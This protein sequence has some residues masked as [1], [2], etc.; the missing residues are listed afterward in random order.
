MC[1]S[2][3]LQL[4]HVLWEPVES[5]STLLYTKEQ[6]SF[7]D[8]RLPVYVEILMRAK[9]SAF[10]L[11][12]VFKCTVLDKITT[13]IF[14]LFCISYKWK[15]KKKCLP[16]F[17]LIQHSFCLSV[18]QIFLYRFVLNDWFSGG[19]TLTRRAEVRAAR[20]NGGR[21]MSAG[22]TCPWP[23]SKSDTKKNM[24]ISLLNNSGSTPCN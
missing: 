10:I 2:F 7:W 3:P 17:L 19:E 21:P 1:C 4:H 18:F 5:S 24:C 23:S 16:K 6:V 15:Y 9:I 20:H 13:C 22:N 12:R 11:K 14:N 8:T